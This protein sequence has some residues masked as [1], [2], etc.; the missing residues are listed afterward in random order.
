MKSLGGVFRKRVD[1][2]YREPPEPEHLVDLLYQRLVR[3]P[4]SPEGTPLHKGVVPDISRLVNQLTH[5]GA[6]CFPVAVVFSDR[7]H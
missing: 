1:L 6:S 4:E 3:D 5:Q 2:F 7:T